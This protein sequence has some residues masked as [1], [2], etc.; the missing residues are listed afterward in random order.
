MASADAGKDDA[1]ELVGAADACGCGVVLD[2]YSD[3]L[4]TDAS[5]WVSSFCF[6]S[7]SAW[8]LGGPRRLLGLS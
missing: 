5:D 3:K 2:G 4:D 8:R 7:A 6:F 1:I